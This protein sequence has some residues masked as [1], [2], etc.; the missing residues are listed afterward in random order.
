MFFIPS[1]RQVRTAA[2][3]CCRAN[4]NCYVM[5]RDSWAR[6][7]SMKYVCSLYYFA[8][9]CHKSSLEVKLE[10]F[11]SFCLVTTLFSGVKVRDCTRLELTQKFHSCRDKCVKFLGYYRHTTRNWT[12]GIHCSVCSGSQPGGNFPWGKFWSSRG[13]ILVVLEI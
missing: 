1:F 10:L 11:L 8:H 2:A 6:L 4:K 9:K 7:Q 5:C 3:Y 13:E 12:T